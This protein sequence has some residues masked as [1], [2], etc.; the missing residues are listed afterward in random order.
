MNYKEID[1]KTLPDS[2]LL[3]HWDTLRNEAK[4]L[5]MDIS[6]YSQGKRSV[7][8]D[9][10][11]DEYSRQKDRIRF[12]SEYS[13]RVRNHK[14]ASQYYT[15]FSSDVSEAS[16]FGYKLRKGHRVDTQLFFAVSEAHYKLGKSYPHNV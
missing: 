6:G 7:R 12:I 13:A 11:R 16:A 9:D 1:F 15:S 3:A 14:G 10:I 4:Q 8:R 5:M 2:E